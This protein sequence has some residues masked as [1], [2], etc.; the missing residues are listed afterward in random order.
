MWDWVMRRLLGPKCERGCGAH[1]YP[2]DREA[3]QKWCS[4][5]EEEAMPGG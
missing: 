3:H 4:R 1:V 5:R 2:K